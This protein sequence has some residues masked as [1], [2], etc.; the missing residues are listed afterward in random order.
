MTRM[1]TF[2]IF[3]A[4]VFIVYGL[5]NTYIYIR[6]VSAIPQ[7]SPLRTWFTW[8]FWFIAL[9]YF[10]ARFLERIALSIFTD[11]LL[12]IGSFWLGALVYFLLI[13][14]LIDIF[15]LAN[16]VVPFF[17]D[18]IKRNYQNVK[19]I[20]LIGSIIIVG[21]I[22][23]GSRI[24]AMFP[25]IKT[26]DLHIHKK[27]ALKELNVVMLSDVHLGTIVCNS[28][29]IRIV[30]KINSLEPDVVLFAGD[31]LDEDVE[32]VI[33]QNLG[34]TLTTI[35]SKY[36]VYGITGNHE[37]IGGVEESCKYLSDNG[38]VMVRDSAVK[39]ADAFILVGREDISIRQFNGR[40]RK[41]LSDLIKDVDKSL[42]I[43][44]MDHQPHRLT[45]AI[46]NG[47]D[48]Q[49]SGHTHNGQLWPLNYIAKAVYDVSWGYKQ[50]E[51]THF[52]ISSGVGTWGP[53]MRSGNYPEIVN[54]KLKFMSY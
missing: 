21:L 40:Q 47:I 48:L 25:R 39:I 17:P 23:I 52:Y 43:I 22:V 1:Q 37:Y 46:E 8:I 19:Q 20:L 16:F 3:L 4:I 13:C 33:R 2:L 36:G 44:M 10:I 42:P 18:M 30:E 32:P 34:E 50:I 53:P 26:I 38:V 45:D 27:S 24:N 49:L 7:S 41:Q 29:F 35:K 11:I 6:G 12:W 15:R 31:L 51:R 5:I 28:H 54:L 14:L 9:S